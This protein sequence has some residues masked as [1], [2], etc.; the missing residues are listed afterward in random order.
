MTKKKWSK[1]LVAL[2]VMTMS[3]WALAG[4]GGNDAATEEETAAQPADENVYTATEVTSDLSI[5]DAVKAYYDAIDMDYAYDLSHELAYSEELADFLGWRS[6]G[7]DSEHKCADFLAKKMEEIGLQNVDKVGTQCDKF[8]FNSSS[9]KI[10]DTD[11]ELTPA[12]YQVNGTDGDLTAEIVDVGTGTEGEYEEAGDVTGKIVLAHVDQSNEAWIDGYAKMANNKGAAAIV[13]WANSGYGEAGTDSVNVQD[14]CCADLLPTTAISADEADK[15][16]EAI[17]AGNNECTLNVD[18]EMVDDGGTTYN[19]V[20]MI[21]GKNHDQKIIVS[22]HYD[23]YWYGFQDDCCAIG[24]VLAVAKGM[25]DSKYEPENDIIFVCH[26]AEEWGSSDCMYDWTTGAWAMSEHEGYADNCLAMINCE[27]PA[28]KN[29]N[30]M[31]VA[32]VPEFFTMVGNMFDRGLLVTTGEAFF[33]KDPVETTTMED[34]IS[35]R[36]HGVPYFLN[37]FE[38]SDFMSQ[39]Y[40][41]SYDDE[42]TYDADTFQTNIDWY[43]A[44]AIYVDKEP[45]LELDLTATAKQLEEN[46]N[47][48]YAEEAGADVEA[49]KEALGNL[50]AAGEALNAEIEKCN[51]AYEEAVA[52]GDEDAIAKAREEGAK[53]NETSLEA[54][55][56]IQDDFLKVTD[57]GS[58]YGHPTVDNNV[59][60]IDGT[61]KG[62]EDGVLWSEAEDGSGACEQALNINTALEYNYC[63]FSKEVADGTTSEYNNSYYKNKDH[64]QWG[65]DHEPALVHTGEA[66][67]DVFHAETADDLDMDKIT[68]IYKDARDGAIKDIGDYCKQEIEDM[69]A[70][71]DFIN[72]AL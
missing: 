28:F 67:Y 45:A 47:M 43:G 6:A 24:L 22:G 33:T 53:L 20:G 44:Y 11:I 70:V 21:P 57:F 36:E 17:K 69:N 56:M 65:W 19:V 61:L 15:V 27:L 30:G 16:I 10:K 2:L 58:Q 23:K 41:T 25:V 38:G 26:G 14:V 34:G 72:G 39:R 60:C 37:S 51:A 59:E 40:H 1:F 12:S 52:V 31:Q 4:C 63:I 35:Y 64:A 71:A 32:A 54:F 18:A 13:T 68:K 29:E 3:V 5:A 66:S 55:Q 8:Q 9:L 46:I 50:T 62:L 48:D 7:S 49:Y 42:G